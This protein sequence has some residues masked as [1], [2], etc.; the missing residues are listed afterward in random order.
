VGDGVRGV[1][2]RE[3]GAGDDGAILLV[4]AGVHRP[5]RL[6][7][8]GREHL[9]ELRVAAVL[10]L[11]GDV[12]RVP[13]Q[14]GDGPRRCVRV[15][16][17]QVPV[18]QGAPEAGD[19]L[20]DAVRGRALAVVRL[21]GER[22]RVHAQDSPDGGRDRLGHVPVALFDLAQQREADL[23]VLGERDLGHA[24]GLAELLDPL[25]DQ[26]VVHRDPKLW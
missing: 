10:Q 5:E 24:A 1:R 13:G 26:L 8:Q 3:Q 14:R 25:A 12:P 19:E 4:V 9:G 23:R 11:H 6:G 2:V 16:R 20:V 15:R 22:A 7:E 21:P 18:V 17:R